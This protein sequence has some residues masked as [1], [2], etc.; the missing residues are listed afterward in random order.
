[1]HD[2]PSRYLVIPKAITLFFLCLHDNLSLFE[3]SKSKQGLRTSVKNASHPNSSWSCTPKREIR[4]RRRFSSRIIISNYYF[5]FV[6]SIIFRDFSSFESRHVAETA[7][8]EQECDRA[9]RGWYSGNGWR[10][11][12]ERQKDFIFLFFF[13]C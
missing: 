9:S 6:F 12:D 5:F 10:E 13:F 2:S 7:L 11:T 1:M 3:R 8:E 4:P